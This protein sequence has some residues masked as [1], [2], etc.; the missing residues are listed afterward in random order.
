MGV[1]YVVTLDEVEV[2]LVGPHPICV[3]VGFFLCFC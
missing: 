3:E 2:H 1:M